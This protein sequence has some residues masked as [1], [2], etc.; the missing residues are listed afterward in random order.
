MDHENYLGILLTK[1][2]KEFYIIKLIGEGA[3]SF[4]YLC[5]DKDNREYAIKLY[6]DCEAYSHEISRLRKIKLSKNIVKLIDNG[7]G[8]IERGCSINSYKLYNNFA[9][10]TVNY[11]LF[12]YL[13]NGELSNYI[14]LLK[15]NFNEE[16]SKKIFI[17]LVKA[18]ETCHKSGI[19]H[20]DIKLENILFSTNFNIKLIDFGFARN[21]QD[22]LI[23]EITGSPYYSAPEVICYATKGYDGVAADIF[24]LGIVLYILVTGIYPYDKPNIIDQRYKMLMKRDFNNFWKKSEQKMLNYNSKKLSEEFKDLF[25]KM[26]CSKPKERITIN[27]IKKHPWI[28]E[29]KKLYGDSSSSD[30]NSENDYI[31]AGG[32]V[33]VKKGESSPKKEK[34]NKLA[35]SFNNVIRENKIGYVDKKNNFSDGFFQVDNYHKKLLHLNKNFESKYKEIDAKYFKELTNRKKDIDSYIKSHEDD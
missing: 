3:T 14:F 4:V 7:Q 25:E 12:E 34:N 1:N 33:S 8:Y 6:K 18:V 5:F 17:D 23:S 22:G 30:D 15:K 20:G 32:K 35:N 21:I 31:N 29:S 2:E 10:E 13:K 26:I 28:I 9:N 27:E 11:A 19:T 16:I 24:S